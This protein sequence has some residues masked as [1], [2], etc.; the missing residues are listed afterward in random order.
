MQLSYP[1]LKQSWA[2]FIAFVALVIVI[3]AIVFYYRPYKE[4]ITT[5]SIFGPIMTVALV[6]LSVS[7]YFKYK[8]DKYKRQQVMRAPSNHYR[9]Q[10]PTPNEQYI[11]ESRSEEM[12]ASE[13][14][15]YDTPAKALLDD[16]KR[17]EEDGSNALVKI[18]AMIQNL[19]NDF[20]YTYKDKNT[21][22]NQVYDKKYISILEP[23][24]AKMMAMHELEKLLSNAK[25][26][27]YHLDDEYKQV[28][29]QLQSNIDDRMEELRS[30][31]NKNYMQMPEI[32]NYHPMHM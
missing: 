3:Y 8:D 1:T 4:F 23:A 21:G 19:P 11:K 31:S 15:K 25:S 14:P 18:D 5:V 7:S 22:D 13:E 17:I 16:M 30:I 24:H 2:I 26:S 9:V 32:H 12:S 10:V 27:F 6:T 28:E 29:K 20:K